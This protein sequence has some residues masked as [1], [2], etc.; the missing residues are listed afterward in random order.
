MKNNSYNS[1]FLNSYFWRNYNKQEV[2][3]IEEIADNINAYE[4]KW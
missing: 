3:Y 2:D 1:I 4:F